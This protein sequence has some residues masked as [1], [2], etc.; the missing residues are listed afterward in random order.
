MTNMIYIHIIVVTMFID[1]QTF[2]Q[3]GKIRKRVLL[4]N[5]Y[6][7]DGRVCHDTIANL[8]ECTNE[9]IEAIKLALKHKADIKRLAD[10]AG[11]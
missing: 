11:Q 5:S 10:V 3:N 1:D 9:E 4:R 2:T 6:R 8:S 7:R